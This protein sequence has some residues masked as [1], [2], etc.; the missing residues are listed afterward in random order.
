MVV[1]PL[2]KPLR[3]RTMVALL[4]TARPL[5]VVDVIMFTRMPHMVPRGHSEGREG[6]CQEKKTGGLVEGWS[7]ICAGGSKQTFPGGACRDAFS[8]H[9]QRLHQARLPL[10]CTS[11]KS[12][13]ALVPASSSVCSNMAFLVNKP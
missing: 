11:P 13:R 9:A 4:S 8:Y 3:K 10:G 5:H 7:Q 6:E 12:L 1:V 2:R